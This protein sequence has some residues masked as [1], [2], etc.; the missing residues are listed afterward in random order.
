M[1]QVL[2]GCVDACGGFYELSVGE[3]GRTLANTKALP[4]TR[5]CLRRACCQKPGLGRM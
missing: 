4:I 1:T 3:P 2:K 5:D